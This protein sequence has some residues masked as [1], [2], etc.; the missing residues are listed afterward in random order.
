MTVLSLDN[1]YEL[2]TLK[3][4]LSYADSKLFWLISPSNSIKAGSEAGTL[5]GEGYRYVQ[6]KGKAYREHRLVYLLVKGRLPESIDHING[7]R[8]DNRIE[9]LRSCTSRENNRNRK[10]SP[11]NKSGVKGVYWEEERS[12]WCARLRTGKKRIN[13]GRFD[14]LEEAKRSIKVAREKYH[15]EFTNHG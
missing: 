14:S 12:K 8:H 2:S 6:F 3:K 11:K 4:V 10:I 7:I 9:N 13:L 5:G 15:K 1:L